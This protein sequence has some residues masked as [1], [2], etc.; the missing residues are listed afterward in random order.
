VLYLH[1]QQQGGN[2]MKANMIAEKH[3]QAFALAKEKYPE[4]PYAA[5]WGS[6]LAYLT[7]EQ[8]EKILHVLEIK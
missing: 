2:K 5:L 6:A 1:H 4:S 3:K 7:D 8:I